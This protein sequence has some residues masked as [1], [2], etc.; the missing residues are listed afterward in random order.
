MTEVEYYLEI[1]LF[2]GPVANGRGCGLSSP[3]ASFCSARQN[4]TWLNVKLVQDR[5]FLLSWAGFVSVVPGG[6]FSTGVSFV[7]S[8]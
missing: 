7:S 6:R 5:L 1:P 8:T 3:R 2:Q 4:C